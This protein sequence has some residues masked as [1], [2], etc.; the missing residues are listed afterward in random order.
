M[1]SFKT[2][3]YLSLFSKPVFVAFGTFKHAR[4]C[5]TDIFKANFARYISSSLDLPTIAA[6]DH[7]FLPDD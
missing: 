6:I 5:Y 2:E 7:S 3:F 4:E 1:Y